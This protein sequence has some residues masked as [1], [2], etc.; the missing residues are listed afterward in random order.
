M[1][2]SD[3]GAGFV[4][5]FSFFYSFPRNGDGNNLLCHYLVFKKKKKRKDSDGCVNFFYFPIL[6]RL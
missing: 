5:I 4:F 6:I 1:I 3:A 2:E